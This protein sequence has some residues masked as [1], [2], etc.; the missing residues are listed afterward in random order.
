MPNYLTNIPVNAQAPAL[1]PAQCR[2]NWLRLKQVI[3]SEHNFVTT[4]SLSD[5]YHKVITFVRQTGDPATVSRGQLYTKQYTPTESSTSPAARDSLF[6]KDTL[7]NVLQITPFGASFGIRLAGKVNLGAAAISSDITIGTFNYVGFLFA[8]YEASS[9]INGRQSA[10]IRHSTL[11]STF[12]TSTTGNLQPSFLPGTTPDSIRIQNN[13]GSTQDIYY[14]I[15]YIQS[16][17]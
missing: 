5:G 8:H 1:F 10:I 11:Q 12:A 15:L 2:D 17:T 9:I 7:G 6:Y 14:S 4:G 13:S 3:E 16:A